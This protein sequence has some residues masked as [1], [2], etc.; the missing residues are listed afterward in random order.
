V[1]QDLHQKVRLHVHLKVLKEVL[2][3]DLLKA[4]VLTIVLR[5]EHRQKVTVLRQEVVQVIQAEHVVR[6]AGVAVGV[7]AEVLQ[8]EVQQHV[9]QVE[10]DNYM[11]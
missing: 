4:E 2:I 10:E 7:L 8:V 1:E 6:A 9:V 3:R 5:Q 11:K